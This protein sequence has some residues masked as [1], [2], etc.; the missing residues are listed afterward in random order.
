MKGFIMWNIALNQ[1]S[2]PA[3]IDRNNFNRGLLEINSVQMDS[4]TLRR[5]FYSLGHFSKFVDPNAYR[6]NTN[7]FYNDIENVA[8]VNPDNTIVVIVSSRTS[9]QRTIRIKWRSQS[10]DAV[11]PPMSATTFKF[12]AQ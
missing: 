1:S 7:N 3:V 10:F 4:V 11:I 12:L 9:I 2:Q 6:I 8:F 5:G